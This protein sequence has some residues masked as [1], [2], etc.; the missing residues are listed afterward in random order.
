MNDDD[1]INLA[2]KLFQ[3]PEEFIAYYNITL[4]ANNISIRLDVLYQ[5]YCEQSENCVDFGIFCAILLGKAGKKT[6][7]EITTNSPSLFRERQLQ[8]VYKK[9]KEGK[10]KKLPKFKPRT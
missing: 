10:L 4:G 3:T 6:H 8:Y 7:V 2:N 1:L 9:K 5:I